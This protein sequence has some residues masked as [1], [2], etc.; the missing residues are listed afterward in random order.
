[1][2]VIG[3][4]KN[5]TSGLVFEYDMFNT[6]KSWMGKPSTNLLY[7]SDDLYGG[8]WYGYCA[9]N[10][11]NVTYHTTD[12]MAPDSSYNAL[13]IVMDGSTGCGAGGSWGMLWGQSQI[14]TSGTTYTASIYIKADRPTTVTLGLNDSYGAG[15]SINTT[16]QRISI[17]IT[18]SGSGG[19]LDRGLQFIRGDSTSGITLYVWG[20]QLEVGSFAT[21]YISSYGSPTSRSTTQAILDLTNNNIITASSLTYNSDGSFSFNGTSNSL[22]IPFNSSLF[23]FNNEQ[24]IIIWMTNN[25]PS[26]ARRNP[27]DQAYAGA[28]TIT[29]ENDT[30]FDYYYGT[31][32]NNGSTYT[33]L[34]SSFNV[35]VGETAMI[36]I[37]RN[38]ST[39]TWYK[40]GTFSNS[41]SNPYG[42]SVL[43]G[44]NNITIGAGYAGYF[45][46]SLYIVQ[47]YNRCLSAT[48][49]LQN[50][51]AYRGRY[52]L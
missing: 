30:Y 13:K 22:T 25:S 46:G 3:G 26:A 52:G 20:A 37:T 21:P 18:P 47:I 49:I 23:T 15:Y 34:S 45:G 33:N 35:V 14:F 44:T 29:H 41:G 27:Y 31:Q 12:I 5:N 48:E 2:S 42:S 16:W 19:V 11:N 10:M 17:T 7:R 43:T 50:F 32:G 38:T 4:P 36:A 6:K 39:V 1:M 40:N 28:G 8:L 24:T 9:G 51:N